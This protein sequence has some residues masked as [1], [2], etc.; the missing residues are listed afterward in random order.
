MKP[1]EKILGVVELMVENCCNLADGDPQA[2]LE[3]CE[4]LGR[5]CKMLAVGD[6]PTLEEVAKW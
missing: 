6:E 2:Y 1:S 3:E 5:L 4:K